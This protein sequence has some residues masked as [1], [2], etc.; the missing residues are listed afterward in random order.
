MPEKRGGGVVRWDAEARR[1]EARQ[2]LE[3]E[4]DCV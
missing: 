1:G 3:T 4:S 2:L